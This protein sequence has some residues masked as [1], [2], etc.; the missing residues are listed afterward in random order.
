M[1]IE[2]RK[3]RNGELIR[4]WYGSYSVNGHRRARRLGVSIKGKPPASGKRRASIYANP[5][6]H[7]HDIT[8]SERYISQ[9]HIKPIDSG[10]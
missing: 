4:E 10:V 2:F 3:D 6:G 9:S 8:S 7:K 1:G 5:P